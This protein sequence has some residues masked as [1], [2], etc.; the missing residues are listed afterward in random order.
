MVIVRVAD[1]ERLGQVGGAETGSK[2]HRRTARRAI[3]PA[4]PPRSW[5]TM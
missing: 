1:L 4:M 3:A 2:C 5:T